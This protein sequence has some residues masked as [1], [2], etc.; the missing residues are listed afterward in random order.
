MTFCASFHAKM[1]IC[2]AIFST[3]HFRGEPISIR[4]MSKMDGTLPLVEKNTLIMEGVCRPISGQSILYTIVLVLDSYPVTRSKK[5]VHY[6]FGRE[7]SQAPRA[8]SC[9]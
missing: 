9:W 1:D 3:N 5:C 4:Y 8:F 2:L 7:I 6:S